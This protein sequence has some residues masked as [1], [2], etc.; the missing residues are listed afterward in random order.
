[1]WKLI[2]PGTS[3]VPEKTYHVARLIDDIKIFIK[4]NK[5]GVLKEQ[6]KPRKLGR[7]R[8][9]CHKLRKSLTQ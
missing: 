3:T 4:D 8:N 9:L 6:M 1:M 7:A 2:K 5:D